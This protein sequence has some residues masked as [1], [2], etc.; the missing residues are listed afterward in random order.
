M[1]WVWWVIRVPEGE[2][3]VTH[4]GA[5]TQTHARWH[6][7]HPPMH[8][9]AHAHMH[10]RIHTRSDTQARTHMHARAFTPNRTRDT[11]ALSHSHTPRIH[12]CSVPHTPHTVTPLTQSHPLIHHRSVPHTPHSVTPLVYL[13]PDTLRD[14]SGLA[15]LSSL[16]RSVL[17]WP[18][19][20]SSLGRSVC[21]PL[22]GLSVLP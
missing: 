12:H 2:C 10:V 13:H 15:G 20:P 9:R 4:A 14:G 16:G 8:A 11:V 21:P 5:L 1:A 22:A 7:T 18:V 19:C 6:P 3:C 17:P